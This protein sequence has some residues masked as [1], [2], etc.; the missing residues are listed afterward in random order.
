MIKNKIYFTGDI[1]GEFMPLVF[2][3]TKRYNLSDCSVIVCGDI[4]MGFYKFNYYIDMF[5]SMNKKLAKKNIQLYFIRGNHDNPDYFNCTPE[6]LTSF[7]HVHLVRDY[8]VLN[9]GN[10]NVLCVGGATSIDKKYRTKDI[11]WWEFENVLP[12]DK[13]NCEN[14][15]DIVATHCTPIF[16]QPSYKR[17]PWMDDELDE[18]SRVDRIQL[19][20]MYFDLIKNNE[21]K[22]W[23]YG[24][25]HNHYNSTLPTVYF[26]EIDQHYLMNGQTIDDYDY[27]NINNEDE[28]KFIGLDMLK[29]NNIDMY[30]II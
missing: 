3:L 4:G 6:E 10:H 5:K 8:T 2:V 13:L 22:Y 16:C 25:Y 17:M 21:L 24:H 27:N 1:H 11:D 15:V 9:I 30:E 29:N 20:K 12:Y 26:T 14:N 28:C 7:S 23:F 19:A 18:K